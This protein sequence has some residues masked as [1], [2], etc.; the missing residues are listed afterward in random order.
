M[1]FSV[2]TKVHVFR[3]VPH[4]FRR[5]GDKLPGSKKWDEVMSEGISWAL[6]KPAPVPFFI[7]SD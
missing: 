5:Y 1:L 3:G 4:G 6:S 2:P 7:H